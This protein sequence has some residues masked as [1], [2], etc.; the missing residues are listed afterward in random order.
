MPATNLDA[1]EVYFFE[2]FD[3]LIAHKN[4]AAQGIKLGVDMVAQQIASRLTKK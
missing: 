3:D 2:N 4:E 1:P